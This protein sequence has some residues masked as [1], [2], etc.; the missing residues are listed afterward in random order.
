MNVSKLSKVIKDLNSTSLH[1]NVYLSYRLRTCSNLAANSQESA[2]LKSCFCL[3]M[4]N[5]Y[6][7]VTL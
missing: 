5:C 7:P 4:L 1:S 2:H 6:K 3:N